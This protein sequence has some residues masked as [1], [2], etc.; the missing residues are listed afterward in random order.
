MADGGAGPIQLWR[1]AHNWRDVAGNKPGYALPLSPGEAAHESVDL[2]SRDPA[3]A[4]FLRPRKDSALAQ[5]G[6]GQDDP[7]LPPYVGAVPPDAAEPWDW[8]ATWKARTG[9]E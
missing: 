5:E 9:K 3:A 8:D 2:D 1:F 7:S 6:A 4:G